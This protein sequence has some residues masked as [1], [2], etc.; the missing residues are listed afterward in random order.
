MPKGDSQKMASAP[1]KIIDFHTHILPDFDDGP[2]SESEA[3]EILIRLSEQGVTHVVS[4][5]H[6]YRHE[7]TIGSFINR[8]Q[9]AM[10]RLSAY[11]EERG[12]TGIPK[13]IPAAEV[14]FST[15][16]ADDPDL[17]KL[18]ISGTD[19]ML[20]ELP[21]SQ[22]T[23]NICDSF[24]SFAACGRVRCVLAHIER[25]A[26]F[27]DEDTLFELLESAPGQIN[28]GSFFSSSGIKLSSKL[29][30]AGCICALGTDVHNL[31]TRPPKFAEA[32]KKLSRKLGITAFSGIMNTS[33]MIIDNMDI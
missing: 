6:F 20:V 9:L 25:Y 18:C 7:E 22:L 13:I 33:A 5:S 24:R 16:L 26:A 27:A 17:E 12:I 30:K 29:I 19:Y 23:Q 15:A 28:C 4:T 3:A 2:R 8:R 1:E 14:Y 10:N 11:I 31:T 21:Y 32:R